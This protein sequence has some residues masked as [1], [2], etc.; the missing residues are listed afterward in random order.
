M[1][2]TIKHFSACM[3]ICCFL[4]IL[5]ISLGATN[6]IGWYFKKNNEHKQPCLDKNLEFINN[7]NCYYLD[8]SHGDDNAEKVI[9]LTFDAGYENGNIERILDILKEKNVHGAFFVLGHLIKSNTELVKRMREEGH[10]VC[11]HTYS[12][13]NMAK[14]TDS[15]EF[16]NELNKLE[17]LYSNEIGDTMQKF[18]RPPEGCF[19]EDNLKI[20]EANGYK[21]ILWSF[22]YADWDNNK[23]MSPEKAME[24]LINGTHNGEI[25][26]LHPTS[27]T[28]VE[29]L[30]DFIDTLKE[31][32]YRFGTLDE[33]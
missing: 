3:L 10:L 21:T 1:K 8:K 26:L 5:A 4:L 32:G 12:H 23:Q 27:K 11:N 9:Y 17:E 14:V 6:E 24:K 16:I 33:L 25:L 22:A 20:L 2:K 15:A 19:S 29:I 18:Y 31:M 28:N 30:G 13:K 7:Y